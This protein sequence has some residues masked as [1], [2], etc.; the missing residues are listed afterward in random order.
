MTDQR[1][2]D[3]ARAMI[4]SEEAEIRDAFLESIQPADGYW[5]SSADLQAL[6]KDISAP[7]WTLW[8]K[9]ACRNSG[10]EPRQKVINQN[11]KRIRGWQGVRIVFGGRMIHLTTYPIGYRITV[12]KQRSRH[13]TLPNGCDQCLVDA[14][15]GRI[16]AR[17]HGRPS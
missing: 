6:V 13:H 3:N 9:R 1:E 11:G 14:D 16:P 10:V 7:M 2:S 4:Y 17:M 12:I 8:L 5:E 15:Q